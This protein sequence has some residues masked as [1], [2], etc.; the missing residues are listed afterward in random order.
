MNHTQR[1]T[2]NSMTAG[3]AVLAAAVSLGIAAQSQAPQTHLP[4]HPAAEELVITE[5]AYVI[6]DR[7][8]GAPMATGDLP[9]HVVVIDEPLAVNVGPRP[10][11]AQA[12][13]RRPASEVHVMVHR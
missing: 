9:V 5:P 7:A 13:L 2:K 8:P 3:I 12:S 4:T 10:V 11:V 6:V 1:I